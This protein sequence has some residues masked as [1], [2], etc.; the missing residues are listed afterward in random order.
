MD[1]PG[2]HAFGSFGLRG[3]GHRPWTNADVALWAEALPAQ[4]IVKDGVVT[5]PAVLRRGI[6]SKL[7]T[8]DPAATPTADEL[9]GMFEPSAF[10]SLV[11]AWGGTH[12]DLLAWWRGN[13]P[14]EML[15]RSAFPAEVAMRHGPRALLQEPRLVVG[16]IHSVKGGE[17]DVVILFPDLSQ[18][19]DAA[20]QRYGPPRDAVIRMFYVGMTRA[21]EALYLADRAS[22]MAAHF[23]RV[24][25]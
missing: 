17:A 4:D 16:T 20:Y 3:N 21:R 12:R 22:T 8:R 10:E 23:D 19:G 6:K 15:K 18:A 7:K 14:E 2:R 25:H 1:R 24:I 5:V 11:E 13:L 9:Q